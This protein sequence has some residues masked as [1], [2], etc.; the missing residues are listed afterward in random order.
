MH[1]LADKVFSSS[2]ISALIAYVVKFFETL[3]ISFVEQPEKEYIEQKIIEQK[4]IE[5]MTTKLK[6]LFI[7]TSIKLYAKEFSVMKTNKK[8]TMTGV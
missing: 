8:N 7:K 2:L 6:T 4:I 3:S 1:C 5:T